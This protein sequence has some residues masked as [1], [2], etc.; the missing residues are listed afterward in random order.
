M[1]REKE[2]ITQRRLKI[3]EMGILKVQRRNL[4]CIGVK[5]ERSFEI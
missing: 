1:R 5:S 3:D 2:R 4:K